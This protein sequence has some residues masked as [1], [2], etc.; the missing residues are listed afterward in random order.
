MLGKAA[1][2]IGGGLASLGAGS[3]VKLDASGFE[4]LAKMADRPLEELKG[5]MAFDKA[6][7]QLKDEQ[8]KKDPNSEISKLYTQL[9]T[10]AGLLKNGQTATAHALENTGVNLGT[11]LSAIEAG[12]AR[13]DAAALSRETRA[14]DM[15]ERQRMRSEEETLKRQDKRKLITEEVEDRSRN[16]NNSIVTG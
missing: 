11:L 12:K 7:S 9:A 14:S 15:L 8:A 4:D 13:K 2:Q 3:Q 16:L 10:Q 6:K 5:R 1:T